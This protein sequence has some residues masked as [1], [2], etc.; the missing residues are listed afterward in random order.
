MEL[1]LLCY[2]NRSRLDLFVLAAASPY[3]RRNVKGYSWK[4]GSAVE[5]R[6]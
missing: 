2:D 6:I 5:A 3:S 1:S 4:F